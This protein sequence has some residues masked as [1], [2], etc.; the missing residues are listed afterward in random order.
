MCPIGA[1][2]VALGLIAGSAS[3]VNPA[4]VTSCNVADNTLVNISI[5]PDGGAELETYSDV[6]LAKNRGKAEEL[7]VV[8]GDMV[9]YRVSR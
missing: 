7:H 6:K 1:V 8:T 3:E 5:V 9:A 4:V 2:V